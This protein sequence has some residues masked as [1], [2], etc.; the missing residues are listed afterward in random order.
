MAPVSRAPLNNNNNNNDD[1][2]EDGLVV[3]ALR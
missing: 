1:D 3:N 2:D